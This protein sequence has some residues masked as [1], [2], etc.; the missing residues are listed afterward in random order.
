MFRFKKS[1]FAVLLLLCVSFVATHAN[2]KAAT[3]LIDKNTSF[4]R[5]TG[6]GGFVNS[7]QFQYNHMT[8]AEIR[9]L[10][11]K[12]SEMGYN[13]MRIYLPVG[14][15]NWPQSL[16]TARLAKELG[17][18]LFASP[19]SPPAEWKTN[20]MIAGATQDANDNFQNVGSLKV[21]QDRKSVV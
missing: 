6:F 12:N 11:G 2:N 1:F 15:S 10:W 4:Q 21:E 7:P 16:A 20:G 18:I 9:R 5:I 3:I 14:E 17:L 13:I 19:W 8:T